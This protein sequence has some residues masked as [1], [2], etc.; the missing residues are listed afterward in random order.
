MPSH[1]YLRR[2]ALAF[3]G[4]NTLLMVPVVGH[5]APVCTIN[6]RVESCVARLVGDAL[7]VT[8][9]DGTQIQSKRLGRCAEN[10]EADGVMH[11]C[12]VRISLPNDFVYGLQ[13][14]QPQGVVKLIAPTLTVQVEGVARSED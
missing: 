10:R 2:A 9:A 5:S 12:N 3:L 4:A 1:H 8:R 11:R 13:L 14:V 6:G 7:T